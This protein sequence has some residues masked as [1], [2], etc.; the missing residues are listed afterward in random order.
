MRLVT[1]KVDATACLFSPPLAFACV[2]NV[3]I[4]A[5][6]AQGSASDII[7]EVPTYV[8]VIICVFC[9]PGHTWSRE[10]TKE[11]L[12]SPLPGDSGLRT[13]DRPAVSPALGFLSQGP[14]WVSGTR[15]LGLARL[16]G[17]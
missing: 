8:Y 7:H 11:P 17:P 10:K 5:C 4:R 14:T 16:A 15:R 13:E 3:C 2:H 6:R 12:Q 9:A 1:P